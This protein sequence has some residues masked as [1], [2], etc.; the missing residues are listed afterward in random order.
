[1]LLGHYLQFLLAS[2]ATHVGPCAQHDPSERRLM[3]L[4]E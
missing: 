4:V 1:M 2:S 3:E